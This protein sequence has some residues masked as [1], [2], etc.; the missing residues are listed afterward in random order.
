MKTYLKYAL[1]AFFL[2]ILSGSLA[3]QNLFHTT[4]QLWTPQKDEV[5]LQEVSEKIETDKAVES[6]AVVSNQCYALMDGQIYAV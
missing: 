6:V 3:A 4:Q 5:Y 1:F 2:S